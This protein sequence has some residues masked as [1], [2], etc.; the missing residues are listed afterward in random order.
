MPPTNPSEDARPRQFGGRNLALL[1]AAVLTIA[2]GYVV[3][4]SGSGAAEAASVLLVVG[5]CVLFPLALLA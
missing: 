5:Y 3:L 4:S 1:C 2:A